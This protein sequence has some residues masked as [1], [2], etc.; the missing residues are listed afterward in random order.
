VDGQQQQKKTTCSVDGETILEE[1]LLY[2]IFGLYLYKILSRKL[3]RTA[4]K[5]IRVRSVANIIQS[6]NGRLIRLGYQSGLD[7]VNSN[8]ANTFL[9]IT[10]FD[11]NFL[12]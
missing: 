6:R 1:I 8:R 5:R 2:V 7:C 3:N 4:D 9:T 10:F 11:C 12:A